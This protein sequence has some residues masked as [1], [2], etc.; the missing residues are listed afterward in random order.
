MTRDLGVKVE[1]DMRDLNQCNGPYVDGVEYNAIS[2]PSG[3]ES[4]R[5]EQFA[6]EYRQ[7][8][9]LIANADQKPVILH[10]T[11]GCDRTGIVTMMLLTVCG[12]SYEDVARDYLF[13]NFST[14]GQ[15][16][17]ESEF[18]NWWNKLDSFSGSTKAE[19]AKSWLLSKGIP[20]TTVQ[21][22]RSIFVEGYDPDYFGG[23]G[24]SEE[25]PTSNGTINAQTSGTYLLEAETVDITHHK[26]SSD[27]ASDV[28]ERADASG[29][30]FLAAATGNTSSSQ[31]FEFGFVL[32]KDSFVTM[33][34][35]YA[36][37]ANKKGY[38]EDM[39][40]TYAYTFYKVV[41]GAQS[42]VLTLTVKGNASGS[43]VLSARSD[44]TVWEEF[45]YNT[46]ALSA[47]SYVVRVTV[48]ENTNGKG[49]PNVDY[50]RFVVAERTSAVPVDR[51]IITVSDYGAYRF[52]AENANT[53]HHVISSD[54][55]DKVVERSEASCGKFLAA[56]TGNPSSSQYF[57]FRLD[58]EVDADVTM[59]AS[60]VQTAK[61]KGND[62]DMTK[63]YAYTF[64]K[65]VN[66]I[67]TEVLTLAVSGNASGSKTLAARSDETAWE[68]FTYNTVYLEAGSYVVRVT[69]IENTN[70]KGNPNVDYLDFDVSAH[71]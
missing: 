60:Y 8:F 64:Y 45:T 22:I 19:K 26:R 71:V 42:A 3:T 30:K 27:N 49:N 44:E 35:A 31:Y 63:T 12:A 39:T 15:R 14:Q 56:A 23:E 36:Q 51:D 21:K 10:C 11:A 17:L 24:E 34:A 55:P 6:S 53:A 43:K 29:G 33:T 54:N 59:T 1:I 9:A 52:E 68:E 40:K 70:G 48:I 28:V 5:F 46:E 32:G 13:S 50:M 16:R 7:I 61:K 58:L 2:V 37:T 66:G 41:N 20:E 69:V 4:T 57:E 67:E 47:G 25:Q 18:V 65:V 38:D 62:Q